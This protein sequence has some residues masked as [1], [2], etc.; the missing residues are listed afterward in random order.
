[1]SRKETEVMKKLSHPN[2]VKMF[3]IIESKTKLSIVQVQQRNLL[4]YAA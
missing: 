2:I 3:G 1:V 4:N